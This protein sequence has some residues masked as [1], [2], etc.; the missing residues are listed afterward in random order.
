MMLVPFTNSVLH[1]RL[2][3]AAL[4]GIC[5][6]EINAYLIYL[7]A[8]MKHHVVDNH[9]SPIVHL[10][11]QHLSQQLLHT[12]IKA[13]IP[14]TAHVMHCS[15]NVQVVDASIVPNCVMAGMIAYMGKMKSYVEMVM[16]LGSERQEYLQNPN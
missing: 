15:F 5:S 7:C 6:V 10:Y 13:A 9:T 8:Q 3:L 16:Q 4:Q 12:V 1:I 11:V 14:T 2:R